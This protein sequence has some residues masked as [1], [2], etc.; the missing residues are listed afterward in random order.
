MAHRITCYSHKP[1]KTLGGALKRHFRADYHTLRRAGLSRR[2]AF[3]VCLNRYM[4]DSLAA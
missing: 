3:I 4:P 2:Q 1:L